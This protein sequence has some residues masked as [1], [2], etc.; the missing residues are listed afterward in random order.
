[1]PPTPPLSLDALLLEVS[2]SGSYVS[3]R[4]ERG[5]YVEALA[6]LTTTEAHIAEVRRRV[7]AIAA[8]DGVAAPEVLTNC[9]SCAFDAPGGA[10]FNLGR[11]CRA[12]TTERA[13]WSSENCEDSSGDPKSGATG[14]PSHKARQ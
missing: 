1:M 4:I 9:D 6:Q 7:H 10:P 11:G 2:L 12:Y 5:E 3:R 14:C 13:A 8:A